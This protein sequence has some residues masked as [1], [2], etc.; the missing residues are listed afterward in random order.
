ML[1]LSL[2][3]CATKPPCNGKGYIVVSEFN[4]YGYGYAFLSCDTTLPVLRVIG[5]TNPH[6]PRLEANLIRCVCGVFY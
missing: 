3:G 1:L 2:G 5:C 4:K 6:S